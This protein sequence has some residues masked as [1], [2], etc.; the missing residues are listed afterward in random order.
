MTI[1]SFSGHYDFLSN[2]HP[3]PIKWESLGLTFPTAEHAFQAAKVK[4]Q[5]I[6]KMTAIAKAPNPNLAKQMGR[7]VPLREDWENIKFDMMTTILAAKFDQHPKFRIALLNTR[8]ET[9][10][11]GNHWHDQIWGDCVCP[12]H[13]GVQGMNALG[14]ILM[15]L[16]LDFHKEA[17]K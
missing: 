7:A 3:S 15:R 13:C 14:I 9:L 8:N 5:D 11:E 16:R 12:K 2:F 4:G 10:V 1:S 17:A 6:K